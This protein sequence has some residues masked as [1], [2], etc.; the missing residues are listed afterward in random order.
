VQ[1]VTF[2]VANANATASRSFQVVIRKH[3]LVVDVTAG[4]CS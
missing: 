3:C 2:Q 1:R 4:P